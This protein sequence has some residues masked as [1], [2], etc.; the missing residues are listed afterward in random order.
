M[1]TN[2]AEAVESELIW[3]RTQKKRANCKH[4]ISQPV[5]LRRLRDIV[6]ASADRLLDGGCGNCDF[7]NSL[8]LITTTQNNNE[9][10]Q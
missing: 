4:F 2:A 3:K 7:C 9:A 5:L 6:L 1:V 10:D 8:I